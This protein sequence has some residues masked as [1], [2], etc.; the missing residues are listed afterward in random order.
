MITNKLSKGCAMNSFESQS[1][2]HNAQERPISTPGDFREIRHEVAHRLF[3]DPSYGVF[4]AMSE[5]STHVDD[6]IDKLAEQYPDNKL[7]VGGSLGRREMLPNSDIDLFVVYD[8]ESYTES[9]IRVDGVDKFEIGHINTDNLKN[10][11]NY[12]LVDANRFIDGRRVGPVPAPDVE[13]MILEA[14]TQ[15]HQLANNISEYFFYRYFDFPNKTTAMGPNLKYSTGSSRDTIFFNMISRMR[16]GDFPAIRGDTPE[17]AVVMADAESHYGVRAPYDAVNLLFTVKNAAIS[18]YDK[19][20]DPRSRYVSPTSLASIY[21]FGKDKFTAWGIK[22]DSQFIDTYSA[23]RKELELTVDTIFTKALAEHPAATDMNKL[24]IAEQGRRAE[25][26]L[27]ALSSDATHPHALASLGAWLTMADSPS[28]HSMSA[29]A[30][31]LMDR[32]LDESWGGLMAVACSPATSD[33][34]LSTM[35][36]WLYKNEKGA[37]LTKLITRNPAASP[38]TKAKALAY[39]KDKEIIT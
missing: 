10:L 37:Y 33:A 38:A 14:N 16:T 29:I 5:M 2:I 15:D 32:P 24:L 18:V 22:S 39:Y 27:D 36:D 12:S 1:P 28:E 13:K 34:T 25:S 11:L 19:T 17:L 30:H 21:E 9:G 4:D 3:K 8:E 35:A 6:Y 26:C 20:G 7:W 23:A 31:V